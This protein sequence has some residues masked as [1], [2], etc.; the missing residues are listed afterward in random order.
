VF[1]T[2]LVNK[3]LISAVPRERGKANQCYEWQFCNLSTW[4]IKLQSFWERQVSGFKERLGRE[5]LPLWLNCRS[6]LGIALCVFAHIWLTLNLRI[7]KSQKVLVPF[8]LIYV[9]DIEILYIE[10]VSF[11]PWLIMAGPTLWWVFIGLAKGYGLYDRL[12]S[13]CH[14]LSDLSDTRRTTQ[15]WQSVGPAVFRSSKK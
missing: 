10:G 1:G 6:A 12:S 14:R 2:A 11:P 9:C 8:N 7:W 15:R 3:H 13:S 5:L 4:V